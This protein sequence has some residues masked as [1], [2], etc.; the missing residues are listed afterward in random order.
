MNSLSTKKIG[1]QTSSFVQK[2]NL[3]TEEALQL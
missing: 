1:R 2:D 3:K